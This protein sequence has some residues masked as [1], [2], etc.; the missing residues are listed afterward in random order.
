MKMNKF[1][2]FG[3]AVFLVACGGN[4]TPPKKREIKR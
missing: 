3:L 4:E 1:W 2:I